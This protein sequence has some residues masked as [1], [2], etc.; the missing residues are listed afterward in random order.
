MAKCHSPSGSKN[1]MMVQYGIVSNV[2]YLSTS[3]AVF[4]PH[5]PSVDA[6]LTGAMK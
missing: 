5:H 2:A 4:F 6:L 3:Q 1:M